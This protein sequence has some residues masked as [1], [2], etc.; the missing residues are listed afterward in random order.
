M[1]YWRHINFCR[2]GLGLTKTDVLNVVADYFRQTK[3]RNPFKDGVPRNNWWRLFLK[4][5]QTELSKRKPQ[6]DDK[7]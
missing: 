1:R 4:R 6:A 5:H 3:R 2:V 7:G